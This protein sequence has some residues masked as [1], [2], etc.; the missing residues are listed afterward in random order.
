VPSQGQPQAL[1]PRPASAPITPAPTI[2]IFDT[3]PDGNRNVFAVYTQGH[4]TGELDL[5]NERQVL[6]SGRANSDSRPVRIKRADFRLLVS[7][8]SD[9]GEVVLRAIILGRVG[10]IDRAQGG[11]VLVGNGRNSDTLRLHRFMTRN[12][13][14]HRSL[15]IDVDS[16]AA[17][18]VAHFILTPDQLPVVIT[19]GQPVLRNPSYAALADAL[20][21]SV[22]LDPAATYDLAIIGAGPAG[23]AAAVYASSEGLSALVLEG[24]A[25]GGQAG[26]S[27]KIENYL[28]F[29]NGIWGKELASR[30]QTQAQKFGAR[31]AV[32]RMVVAVDASEHRF[33]LTLD[34][35]QTVSGR[36][37][38]VATGA[39]YGQLN[40]ENYARFENEGIH[41]AATAIEAQLCIGQEVVVVGAGNSAGQAAVYLSRTARHVHIL[42]R[43]AGLAESMSDYLVQRLETSPKIAVHPFT[44]V[45]VL[46]GDEYLRRVT[47]TNRNTGGTVVKDITSLFVMI[48]ARPNTEW[49]DNCLQLD[50][51]GFILTGRATDRQ[52]TGSSFA[53]TRSGVFAVG[54]VRSGSSRVNRQA[55]R[56]ILP[57]GSEAPWVPSMVTDPSV[58]TWW[59]DYFEPL[60]RRFQ[61]ELINPV[62]SKIHRFEG[63]T[64]ARH[65]VGQPASTI[66]PSVWLRQGGIVIVN[67]ARGIVGDNAA[68]LIGSTLL[69]LVTLAVAEQARLEPGGRWP[70]SMFVDES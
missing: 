37:V 43:G 69:N 29:P 28:G 51:K 60:D 70:I 52:V 65:I 58:L 14:P 5:L 11:I 2:E 62:L 21:L 17:E 45:S 31:L 22:P 42:A 26:T 57:H 36:S 49:L 54:D 6:A 44:E 59:S 53:T 48:G 55:L 66:D 47:W 9:I 33:R 35:G 1:L 39:R 61:L 40:V 7:A 32:S 8:E 56:G 10:A 20:G 16:D 12:G 23:L 3:D 41:Y 13:Y 30:A 4:F 15:E 27:S 68:A 25:S 38:V 64:A 50:A 18:F 24:E 67:T 46:E 63:S 19:P 34:D